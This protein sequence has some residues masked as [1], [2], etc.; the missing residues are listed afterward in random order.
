[1]QWDDKAAEDGPVIIVNASQYRCDALIVPSDQDPVHVPID[2]T[3]T[4]VSDLSSKFQSLQENLLVSILRKIWHKVVVSVAQALGVSNVRSGSRIWWCPTAEFTLL[5]LHAAGAYEKKR[6][7]LSHIY[8]SSYTPTLATL[9]RARRQVSRDGSLQHFVVIGQGNPDGGKPLEC[10]AP[11][12]AFVA[13]RLAPAVSSFTSLEDSD[14]TVKGAFDALNRNQWLHLACHGMPNRRRP[15]ESSFAM[16]DAPLMIKD[17][18]RSN[19]HEPQVPMNRHLATAMQFSGFRGVIGSMWSVKDEVAQEVV[20]TFY[21]NLID[22]SGR[23]DCMRA[24][25]A[26]HEAVK[27]LRRSDIPLEQ[28]IVFVHIGV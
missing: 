7:S 17:I 27:K 6:D 18:I 14:A 8:I 2:T 9:V 24:A 28:K 25:M 3:Q 26:L 12:V 11:E 5:P 15:F 10:V 21:D 23:L 22:D 1:M 4:E 16:R 20:S 13:K 19:W